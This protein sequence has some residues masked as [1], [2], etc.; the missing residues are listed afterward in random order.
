MK[1]TAKQYGLALAEAIQG[2]KNK[3]IDS[4]FNNF[5]SLLKKNRDLGIVKK[6]FIEFEKKYLK[7]NGI[8][9]GEINFAR[10]IDIKLKSAIEKKII[11]K[12]LIGT[13]IKELRLKEKIDK[14]MI[15]GFKVKIGDMVVD[16]SMKSKLDNLKKQMSQELK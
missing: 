9:D 12:E 3:E 7:E 4:V 2:K 6:I 5:L 15:G 8:F 11:D 1:Y 14:E 13:K 10:H 16:A